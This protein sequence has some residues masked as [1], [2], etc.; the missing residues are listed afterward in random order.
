MWQSHGRG[1]LRSGGDARG[2]RWQRDALAV[3][4]PATHGTTGC[5]AP[6]SGGGSVSW[7][8]A[9][10]AGGGRWE[11]EAHKMLDATYLKLYEIISDATL[12]SQME[13]HESL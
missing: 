1:P 3:Y 8:R 4:A 12:T 13:K 11:D 6:R 9:A 10:T 7:Q 2:L 5:A